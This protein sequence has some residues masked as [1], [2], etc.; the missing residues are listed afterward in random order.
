M[1]KL[2]ITEQLVE[3]TVVLPLKGCSL[4]PCSKPRGEELLLF[5]SGEAS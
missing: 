4:M 5:G 3:Y 2:F 1:C